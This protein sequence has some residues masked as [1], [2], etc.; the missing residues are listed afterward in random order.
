MWLTEHLS[1][2]FMGPQAVRPPAPTCFS[3]VASQHPPP[4][5]ALLML[6]VLPPPL[7]TTVPGSPSGKPT[8]NLS[9]PGSNEPIPVQARA[10]MYDRLW[11]YLIFGTNNTNPLTGQVGPSPTKNCSRYS[12]VGTYITDV[13]GRDALKY[14]WVGISPSQTELVDPIDV[15]AYMEYARVEATRGGVQ[16]IPQ[17]GFK[18]LLDR[19]RAEAAAKDVRFF[20]GSPVTCLYGGTAAANGS[21]AAAVSQQKGDVYVA[22]TADGKHFVAPHLIF[23]SGPLDVK[24]LGGSLAAALQARAELKSIWPIEVAVYDAFYPQR[25]WEPFSAT[26]YGNLQVLTTEQCTIFSEFP[27]WDGL[28]TVNASRPVYTTDRD[29]VAFW[30][31]TLASGGPKAARAN[32]TKSLQSLFPQE[33]IPQPTLDYLQVLPDGWHRL[34]A[35]AAA[36]GITSASLAKWATAP[37]GDRSLC[38]VGEAYYPLYSG[39]TQGAW[40]SAYGCVSSN[41][42]GLLPQSAQAANAF[43]NDGCDGVEEFSNEVKVPKRELPGLRP[44]GGGSS[45]RS[46]GLGSASIVTAQRRP[47]HRG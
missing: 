41:F 40:A 17:G 6:P 45:R 20:A 38:L 24:R 37:L 31:C 44:D 32:V 3:L 43:I 36:Q 25:F 1:A 28:R 4:F 29:C 23:A 8:L 7:H 15:C 42:Q 21:S 39:W 22:T 14:L 9:A 11:E 33:N 35:G 47:A 10:G 2:W 34:A 46:G 18:E 13:A 12:S 26:M 27:G 30:K 19:A 16:Y 5:V